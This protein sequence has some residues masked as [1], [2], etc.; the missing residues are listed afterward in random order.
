MHVSKNY[1]FGTEG[2]PNSTC[3]GKLLS[4]NSEQKKTSSWQKRMQRLQ[5]SLDKRSFISFL[6]P[7]KTKK[8]KAEI[9]AN[10]VNEEYKNLRCK[11]WGK[12]EKRKKTVSH[13]KDYDNP[14]S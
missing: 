2:Q 12:S 11:T 14:N 1:V 8:K 13:W 3:C 4:F 6:H 9:L 10:T 7:S 5:E